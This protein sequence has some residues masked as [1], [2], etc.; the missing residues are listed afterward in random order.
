[1]SGNENGFKI[2]RLINSVWTQV[3]T[4]AANV[5][6]WANTGLSASTTYYL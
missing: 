6:S 2:Q 3:G 5:N 4:T 1:M